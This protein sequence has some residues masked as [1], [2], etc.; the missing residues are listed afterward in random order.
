M[1]SS[2]NLHLIEL[3]GRCILS[4]FPGFGIGVFGFGPSSP[5]VVLQPLASS[6]TAS[7]INAK[8]RHHL[9]MMRIGSTLLPA[10]PCPGV[11]HAREGAP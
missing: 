4:S 10:P 3:S 9:D 7:L 1:T 6:S 2:R 5:D 11:R 8:I